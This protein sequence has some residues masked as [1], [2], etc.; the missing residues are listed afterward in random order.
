MIAQLFP[1]GPTDADPSVLMLICLVTAIVTL[2][3]CHEASNENEEFSELASLFPGSQR[4][5]VRTNALLD[6]HFFRDPW[7]LSLRL[8]EDRF[9]FVGLVRSDRGLFDFA[10]LHH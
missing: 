4:A 8:R 3:G 6:E 9:L 10:Q 1:R 7:V 2:S 5:R